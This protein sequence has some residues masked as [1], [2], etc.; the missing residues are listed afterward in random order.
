[1]LSRL[2][3]VSPQA[4]SGI[5]EAIREVKSTIESAIA[6][7][8]ARPIL[9]HPLFMIRNPVHYF[10]GLCFQIAR[11][12]PKRPDILAIGGRYVISRTRM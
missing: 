9:F 2:E 10:N 5:A 11:R 6:T 4:L 12:Q 3:K 8:V 7:G 1:M